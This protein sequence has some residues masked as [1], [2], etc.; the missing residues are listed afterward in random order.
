MVLEEDFTD[1]IASLGKVWMSNL[2][3]DLF[4]LFATSDDVVLP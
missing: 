2:V 3:I 1:E 4:A